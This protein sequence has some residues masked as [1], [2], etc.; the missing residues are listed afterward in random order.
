M[1]NL[2]GFDLPCLIIT[3]ALYDQ[4][5]CMHSSML[6]FPS[7][8]S[9]G[10]QYSIVHLHADL[11]Y[12]NGDSLRGLWLVSLKIVYNTNQDQKNDGNAIISMNGKLNKKQAYQ[13]LRI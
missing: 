5:R 10:K 6:D 3:Y 9:Q 13:L 2:S 8:H 4:N 1:T 7:I 12:Y 11:L